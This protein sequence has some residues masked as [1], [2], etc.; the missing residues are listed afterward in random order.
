MYSS[1]CIN[2]EASSFDVPTTRYIKLTLEG[3]V[4]FLSLFCRETYVKHMS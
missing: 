3:N 2:D 1:S 4:G